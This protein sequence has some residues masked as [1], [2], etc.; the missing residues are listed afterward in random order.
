[1]AA[2]ISLADDPAAV[3][4]ET[5]AVGRLHQRWLSTVA[6]PE[7]ALARTDLRAAQRA[8]ASG[9]GK[10][11]IDQIR[12]RLTDLE[13]RNKVARDAEL[14]HEE[15][16]RGWLE[17]IGAVFGAVLLAVVVWVA[18][19]TRR[20]IVLPVRDLSRAARE[21]A[22]GRRDQPV[23]VQ[24]PDEI[25][26]VAADVEAMRAELLD[27]LREQEHLI[28]GLQQHS[29]TVAS[30]RAALGSVPTNLPQLAVA[31]RTLAGDGVLSGDWYDVFR[32]DDGK[33]AITLGDV[34]GH[35]PASAVTALAVKHAL[36]AVLTSGVGPDDAMASAADV[37][38]S[39]GMP[40]P[41]LASVF[42]AILDPADDSIVYANAGHPAA[43]VWNPFSNEMQT[44]GAT[45][46]ILSRLTTR[47]PQQARRCIFGPDAVLA[48]YSDGLTEASPSGPRDEY[49]DTRLCET[50]ARLLRQ[51]D[52]VGFLDDHAQL[53]RILTAAFTAVA[54]HARL[55]TDDAT[56]LV[57]RHLASDALRGG[58]R[59]V[60]TFT[61]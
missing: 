50:L 36:A 54:D 18:L 48:V 28:A 45:G 57:A 22:A 19:G 7:I 58:P 10:G 24:G 34:A 30:L 41:G 43:F 39:T 49:G 42:I 21:V 2:D 60:E 13:D 35:G 25:A 51:H 3:R 12:T 56:L 15:L 38:T 32:L 16:L 23:S 47:A 27:R 8:E 44:L 33:V 61:N 6:E 37:V 29:P 53:E 4:A 17:G 5:L 11:L 59:R 9:R 26:S 31:A 55:I 14:G 46:P 52:P 1:M 20:L 40:T